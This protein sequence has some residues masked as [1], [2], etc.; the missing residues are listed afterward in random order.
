M[1]CG[2]FVTALACAG[3]SRD[4][5]AAT[6]EPRPQGAEARVARSHRE[7]LTEPRPQGAE[8]RVARSHREGLTEPRPQG[9][10]ALVFGDHATWPKPPV[11]A[12]PYLAVRPGARSQDEVQRRL[13]LK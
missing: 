1:F 3:Q 13:T 5:R 4:D 8:A 12:F 9:A 6:T 2:L 10:E 7:G 11:Q